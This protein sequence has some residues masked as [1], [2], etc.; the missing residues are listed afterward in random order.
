MDYL[1]MLEKLSGLHSVSGD[2]L[3]LAKALQAL[4]AP[5]CDTC[6]IDT[7]GNLIAYKR[8]KGKKLMLTAPMDTPGLVVTHVEESGELRVGPVGRLSPAEILHS[9]YRFKNGTPGLLSREGK[10]TEEVKFS[11][12]FLDIGAGSRAEAAAQVQPGDTAMSALPAFALGKRRAALPH[13]SRLCALLLLETL[14][15]VK[16][17]EHELYFV[18]TAQENLGLRGAQTAA[19]R[20]MP[21]VAISLDLTPARALED[22][23]SSSRMGAGVGIKQMDQS[24]IAHPE[25]VKRLVQLAQEENIPFQ[26][27]VIRSGESAGAAIQVTGAGVRTG[28]LSIPCRALNSRLEMVDFG[29]AAAAARL[30]AAFAAGRSD[31]FKKKDMV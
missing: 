8:G 2:E 19:F 9:P 26:M 29:D 15:L 20:I 28:G 17:R 25:I 14:M 18:F 16:A 24:V 13:A 21:E 12:L 3:P 7:L 4:A 23:Q 6:E 30:L 11:E 10:R 22:K 27:D 1:S 31:E 5:H